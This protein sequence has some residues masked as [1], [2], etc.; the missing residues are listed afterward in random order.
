[1]LSPEMQL[2]L[3]NNKKK[4]SSVIYADAVIAQIEASTGGTTTLVEKQKI[5]QYYNLYLQNGGEP[6]LLYINGLSTPA[7]R[8]NTNSIASITTVASNANSINGNVSE[9]TLGD[10][11]ILNR[12]N[13]RHISRTTNN[14]AT[15]TSFTYNVW[16]KKQGTA[17][18]TLFSVNVFNP[19]ISINGITGAL[20]LYWQGAFRVTADAMTNN[21]EWY[22]ITVTGDIANFYTYVNGVLVN[23]TPHASYPLTETGIFKF[24]NQASVPVNWNDGMNFISWHDTPLNQTQITNIYN[25]TL[26]HFI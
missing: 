14:T 2:L 6:Q 4:E 18:Q 3:F 24:G 21:N 26:P 12:A 15:I 9:I 8:I 23:T 10:N 25:S 13:N 19:R 5:T 11:Y 22:M 7:D 1:M 16:A 20:N 17:D